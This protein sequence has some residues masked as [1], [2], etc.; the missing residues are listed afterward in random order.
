MSA[1]RGNGHRNLRASRPLLTQSGHRASLNGP[2][3]NSY[4]TPVQSLGGTA[5]RRREFITFL[6]GAVA[7]PFVAGAQQ[8]ER[9]RRIGILLPATADDSAFQALVGALLQEL[10]Q[11]GWSIGRNLQIDIRW[12]TANV[13]DIRKHAAELVALGPD[14]IVAHGS[15]SVRP[16]AQATRTVP[17]V[18]PVAS[19]PVGA[20]FVDSLARPGGN[21]TGF[22][23]NDFSIGG[24]WLELLKQVAPTTTRAAVLR[25]P[26]QGSGTSMF[27]V[28]QAVSPS[29]QVEVRPM[30]VGSADEIEQSINTFATASKSGLIIAPGSWAFRHRDLVIALA[31]RHRL[32]AVYFNR[33]FVT[34]GGFNLLWS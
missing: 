10:Q 12:A 8:P 24:K 25:D 23:A 11:L 6:G 18:F 16:L 33:V 19:D 13:G 4:D 29:L 28:I 21:I 9:V 17:I 1:F 30:N 26:A 34:A 20:G 22:M 15:T 31:A 3:F 2:Q 14:V 5:M 32:P 7:F 27:A